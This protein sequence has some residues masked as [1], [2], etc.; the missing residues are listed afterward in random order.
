VRQEEEE[1]ASSSRGAV[2]A[3]AEASGAGG[4]VAFCVGV[5]HVFITQRSAC[6][7]FAMIS[8]CCVV[9]HSCEKGG[10]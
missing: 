6:I 1:V 8:H 9:A 3:F 4:F 7:C 2:E 5:H 10:I